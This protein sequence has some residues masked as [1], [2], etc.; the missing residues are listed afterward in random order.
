MKNN[1]YTIKSIDDEIKLYKDEE[2]LEINDLDYKILHHFLIILLFRCHLIN[3]NLLLV[4]TESYLGEFIPMVA[5]LIK[6]VFD[7]LA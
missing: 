5:F 6:W 2:L 1:S 7:I 3:R 4:I